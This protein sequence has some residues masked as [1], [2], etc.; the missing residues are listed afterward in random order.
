[1]CPDTVSFTWKSPPPFLPREEDKGW[2]DT[3]KFWTPSPLPVRRGVSRLGELGEVIYSCG[4]GPN[5]FSHCLSSLYIDT[6]GSDSA[7]KK[8][9]T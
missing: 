4:P 3:A 2:E 7:W 9:V 6:A 5:A 8:R 1:M